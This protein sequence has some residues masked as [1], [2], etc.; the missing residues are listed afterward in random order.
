MDFKFNDC[1]V[2]VNPEIIY[3][4]EGDY[5]YAW[6]FYELK[7]CSNSEGLWDLGCNFG[8]GGYAAS[9]S[10]K[11]SRKDAIDKGWCILIEKAKKSVSS[12]MD[13]NNPPDLIKASKDLL[14]YYKELKAPKQICLF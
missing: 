4:S 8:G 6:L 5:R 13:I 9:N 14:K 2:C 3:S 1:G 10:G 12:K 11:L 7:I